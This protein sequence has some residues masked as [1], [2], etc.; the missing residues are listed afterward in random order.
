MCESEEL[1][2]SFKFWKSMGR[3]ARIPILYLDG[4]LES[5]QP[6]PKKRAASDDAGDSERPEKRRNMQVSK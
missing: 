5:L 4:A 1:D 6:R 3:L 2:C